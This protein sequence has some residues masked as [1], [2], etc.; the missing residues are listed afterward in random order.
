MLIEYIFLTSFFLV[1]GLAAYIRIRHPFWSLQPVFHTYDFWRYWVMQPYVIE[2]SLGRHPNKFLKL[3]LVSTKEFL[4]ASDE[5]RAAVLDLIQ[6]KYVS[7]EQMTYMILDKDLHVQCTHT[8][9]A[10]GLVSLLKGGG[11]VDGC[12][13]SYPVR[14]CHRG[15]PMQT[16]FYWEYV[17]VRQELD[18]RILIQTHEYNQ[19]LKH[20]DIPASLFR[21]DVNLSE[22]IVPVVQFQVSKFELTK[23]VGKPPLAPACTVTR[24]RAETMHVIMDFLYDMTTKPSFFKLCIFPEMPGLQARIES[25]QWF[26]Y[27]MQMRD[28]LLA[29][30]A[31]KD[32]K[33]MYEDAAAAA[34]RSEIELVASLGRDTD[35]KTLFAGFLHALHDLMSIR[36]ELGFITIPH[37][38]HNHKI[39][40]TWKWKYG[41][42]STHNAALYL[43]NFVCPEC[44]P[45][46][47]WIII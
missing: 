29:V 5:E 34:A 21:K 22:G 37:M 20:P 44:T 23:S 12:M 6:C 47:A 33:I 36:P 46:D 4:D 10:P 3:D 24:I 15:H 27:T 1:L 42:C 25:N 31:L 7:S 18:A 14:F 41:P 28:Q 40:E 19:R 9:S 17:V 32:S 8:I 38:S 45:D 43:Y 35:D 11:G 26:F 39:V 2:S 13:I 30:Y 16:L